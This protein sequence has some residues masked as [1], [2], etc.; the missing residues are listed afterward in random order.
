MKNYAGRRVFFLLFLAFAQTHGVFS[1]TAA[2][3]G[4]VVKLGATPSDAVLDES[5]QQLY[6]V[7]QS[8]NRIDILST[9][10]NSIVGNIPVGQGPLSAAM[11]MDRNYLYVTNATSSSVSVIDLTG[12]GVVQTVSMPAI[13]QGGEVGADGR[14][15][16]STLGTTVT[17]GG[18]TTTT[19][20]LLIFDRAQAATNQIVAI[21]TPPPPSTP[22][23][24]PSTTLTTPTTKFLSKLIRTPNGQYII[25]LTNPTATQTYLFVYEASS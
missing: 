16:V 22:A 19:N 10:T 21:Q 4:Q 24:L 12:G 9:S 7:N 8:G 25:G 14:A 6:L 11:S 17:S 20:T 2:T 13:P 5:R 3:F 1:Q 23:P 15:L 18:V